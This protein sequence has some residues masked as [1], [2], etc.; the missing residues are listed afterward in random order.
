MAGD[1]A[2]RRA[3]LAV[4]NHKRRDAKYIVAEPAAYGTTEDF[5]APTVMHAVVRDLATKR[6]NL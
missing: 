3:I 5:T 4:F 1:L 6:H 2:H